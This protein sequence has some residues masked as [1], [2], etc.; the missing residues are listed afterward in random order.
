MK[1]ATMSIKS[2]LDLHYATEPAEINKLPIIVCEEV[3]KVVLW[4]CHPE[5]QNESSYDLLLTYKQ[6]LSTENILTSLIIVYA[7]MENSHVEGIMCSNL[8][9][10]FIQE[11][12]V[13]YT[14]FC[15]GLSLLEDKQCLVN[16]LGAR[17]RIN[18]VSNSFTGMF[19]DLLVINENITP[20]QN[21][22]LMT[23][24]TDRKKTRTIYFQ[25]E[26]SELTKHLLKKSKI[27]SIKIKHI[28]I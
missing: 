4:A 1:K 9:C 12:C 27:G 17:F 18:P 11:N 5:V 19:A 24:K 22:I 3:Q 16:P 7:W 15:T 21:D 10:S 14:K 20:E 8:P 13:K 6:N 28:N 23:R 25:E 2:L 26:G